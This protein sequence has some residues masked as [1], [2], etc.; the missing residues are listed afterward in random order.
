MTN[1]ANR[2]S[3]RDELLRDFAELCVHNG[4]EVKDYRAPSPWDEYEKA[5]KENPDAVVI[6]RIGDFLKSSVNKIRKLHTKCLI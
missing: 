1:T 3:F 2:M 6:Q 4:V 5:K